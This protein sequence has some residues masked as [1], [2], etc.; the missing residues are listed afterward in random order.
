MVEIGA[1]SYVL[2]SRPP[3]P[4]QSLVRPIETLDLHISG[5]PP[6]F[7]LSQDQTLKKRF[8]TKENL[9]RFLGSKFIGNFKVQE[10]FSKII[11]Y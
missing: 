7:I 5:T 2:L 4:N 1:G 3:L 6:T 11:L 9:T 10:M 8:S